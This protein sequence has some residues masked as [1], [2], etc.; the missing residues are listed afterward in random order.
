MAEQKNDTAAG[1]E[2][3]ECVVKHT[4]KDSVFTSLFK[5]KNT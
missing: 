5:E 2:K 1:E 4:V 3:E